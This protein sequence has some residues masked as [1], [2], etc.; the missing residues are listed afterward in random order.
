MSFKISERY[1][2]FLT[3]EEG[4]FAH[5]WKAKKIP[6]KESWPGFE[7]LEFYKMM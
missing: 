5:V 1:L 7:Q 6:T 2:L 4:F 3:N